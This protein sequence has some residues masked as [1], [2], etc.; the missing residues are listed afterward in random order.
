MSKLFQEKQI[1]IGRIS[2]IEPTYNPSNQPTSIIEWNSAAKN[3][4]LSQIDITYNAGLASSVVERTFLQGG[5]VVETYTYT[6]S[7]TGGIINNITG[8]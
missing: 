5:S 1:S 3:Y 6:P 4:K 2:Y 7:Y 8:S